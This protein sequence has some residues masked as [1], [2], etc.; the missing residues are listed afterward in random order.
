MSLK[1]VCFLRM[2]SKYARL[3]GGSLPSNPHAIVRQIAS[4]PNVWKSEASKKDKSATPSTDE[5]DPEMKA[6]VKSVAENLKGESAQ[7]ESDILQ[8]LRSHAKNTL[9]Q[10][11]G[12]ESPN[13]EA[14]SSNSM[15]DLLSQMRITKQESESTRQ[16]EKKFTK[17]PVLRKIPKDYTNISDSYKLFD[18]P[19]LGIFT[20]LKT[21]KSEKRMVATDTSES[22]FDEITKE[23]FEK[24]IEAPP[25]NAF[26]E[27][28]QWTKEGKLWTFPIN[29]EAGMHEE[30]KVEFH[31]HIFLDHLISDFPK[32]GPIR[33]FMELVTVGLSKNPYL[34]V[35]QK[36]EHIEWFR[37]YFK[38]KQAILEETLGSEG[39]IGESKKMAE[40]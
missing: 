5:L 31:E 29:N 39:V 36:R 20:D 17:G 2:I 38:E 34:T 1:C 15:S 37:D 33:H 9:S 10:K 23:E 40:Q 14:T 30:R 11:D 16:S 18:G 6:A 32:K 4:S 7:A 24:Y 26:E 3:H 35:Q 21:Q 27:M 12:S 25:R 13:L 8:Q 28:I 19:G 22:L